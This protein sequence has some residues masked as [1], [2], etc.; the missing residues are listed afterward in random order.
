[1][2]VHG[3]VCGQGP[4]GIARGDN[5]ARAWRPAPVSGEKAE[6]VGRT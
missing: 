4:A 3:G 6:E 1:M 2:E 5:A